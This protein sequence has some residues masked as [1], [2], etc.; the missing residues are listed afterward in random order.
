MAG[1]KGGGRVLTDDEVVRLRERYVEMRSI[2]VDPDVALEGRAAREFGVSRSTVRNI[3]IG[4]TRADAGGPI[5]L[6]RAEGARPVPV[7][8]LDPPATEIVVV[9]PGD[10]PQRLRRFIYPP[11]TTVWVNEVEVPPGAYSH[12][13]G[14]APTGK[15]ARLAARRR[16]QAALRARYWAGHPELDSGDIETGC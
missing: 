16:N 11:G 14:A 12:R 2:S 7:P 15:A 6:D 10:S 3:V 4:K 5:D 8:C 9:V 1:K 13:G